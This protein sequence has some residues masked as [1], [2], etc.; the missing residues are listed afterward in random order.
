MTLIAGDE[1]I[2]QRRLHRASLGASSL[3]FLGA[4]GVEK[5]KRQI[6]YLAS[7]LMAFPTSQSNL[8]TL[9]CLDLYKSQPSTFIC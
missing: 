5:Y 3:A 1:R 8:A 2:V 6:G 9:I 7:D 4:H